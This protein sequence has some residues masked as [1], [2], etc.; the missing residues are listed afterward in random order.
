MSAYNRPSNMDDVL[1]R[2][3]IIGLLDHLNDKLTIYNVLEDGTRQ[4]VPVP[5]HF[6]FGS[7]ERFMQ[8]F[9]FHWNVC[10][11]P[12]KVDG[13]YDPIP[14]GVISLASMGINIA[15]LTNKFVMGSHTREI[16]GQILRYVGNVNSI[17][18]T[19]SFACEI[20]VDSVLDCFKVTQNVIST[21]YKAQSFSV[22][23]DGFRVPVQ[24]GFPDD[25]DVAAAKLLEYSYP[26]ENRVKL[27]FSFE[28]ET[29]FPVITD[30]M[31]AGRQINPDSPIQ[32]RTDVDPN[33]GTDSTSPDPIP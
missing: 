23:F 1:L 32:L 4:V 13:N 2:N 17:P 26:E 30:E 28:V 8:D 15:A 29:Y 27:K 7:D 6:S 31:F 14:R 24:V 22:E 18:L 25:Y 3:V 11:E 33:I 10:D 16:D 19:I 9:F 12:R 5:F 20:W 21:Y